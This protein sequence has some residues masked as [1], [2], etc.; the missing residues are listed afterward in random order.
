MNFIPELNSDM[1]DW[2]YVRQQFLWERKTG[3]SLPTTWWFGNKYIVRL[4]FQF[5]L[6]YFCCKLMTLLCVQR[7]L[8]VCH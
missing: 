4:Y 6:F 8:V 2:S 5:K 3:Q 7:Y 1:T